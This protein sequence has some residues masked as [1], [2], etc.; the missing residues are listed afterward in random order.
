ME[1]FEKLSAAEIQPYNQTFLSY[2]ANNQEKQAAISAQ[3]YTRTKLREK[4]IAEKVLTP[5]DIANDDLM[6]AQDP[7]TQ[8]VWIDREPDI[9]PTYGISVPL[10]TVPDGYVFKGTRYGVFFSRLMTRLFKKDI[11]QLRTYSYDIRQILLEISTLDL[12]TTIDTFFFN[13]I[14]ANIGVTGGTPNT[15]N[16]LN[17]LGL[18][19][20]ISLP[21][22]TRDNLAQAYKAMNK[23]QVPFGPM[24]PD[25]GQAGGVMVMN[26]STAEDFIKFGRNE[27]GGDTSEK[28]FQEGVPVASLNGV[29][30]VYTIKYNIVP[31][32][33]IYF[34]A[35]E[36]FLGRYLRLQ[37]L[38]C[39]ME[40]KAFLLSFF[41][42]LEIGISI[43]NVRGALLAD[44]NA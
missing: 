6:P 34:F 1:T 35:A 42:Y 3:T 43:G 44:F 12:A 33:Q 41:Q 9:A 15:P 31:D 13:T 29:K 8:V 39:F 22:L 16:P 14:N 5:I 11:S 25:G 30:A 27:A 18:P 17:Q 37:P 23:L 2:L 40:S 4:S 20:Y 26:T 10:N 32:G 19:Q 28:M 7:E 36:E 38:T 21:G 24:Q